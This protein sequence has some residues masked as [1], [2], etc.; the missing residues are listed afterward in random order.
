[1][2]LEQI[3]SWFITIFENN[4]AKSGKDFGQGFFAIKIADI[5][6]GSYISFSGYRY[7][8]ILIFVCKD[9]FSCLVLA[10]KIL[11]EVLK[12]HLVN[13]SVNVVKLIV[14]LT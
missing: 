4:I 12:L 7:F 8:K 11:L 2:R 10:G 5:L 13:N 14:Y 6:P 1:M 9:P 3:T